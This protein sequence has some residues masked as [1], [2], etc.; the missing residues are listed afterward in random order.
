M[1]A[2]RKLAKKKKIPQ[3]IREAFYHVLQCEIDGRR[4]PGKNTHDVHLQ[5]AI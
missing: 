2:V 4:N 3:H 1:V 5:A